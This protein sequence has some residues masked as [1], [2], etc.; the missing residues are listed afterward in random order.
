MGGIAVINRVDRWRARWR[1]AERNLIAT[2]RE[3]SQLSNGMRRS[4]FPDAGDHVN[5]D[6][7]IQ[8][9]TRAR[10][11]AGDTLKLI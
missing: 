9:S 4:V 8:R 3:Q 2:P 5:L 6:R 11:V 7:F 1:E 10:L